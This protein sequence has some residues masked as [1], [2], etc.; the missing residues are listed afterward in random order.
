M[1]LM[2]DR[3]AMPAIQASR[4]A[5]AEFLPCAASLTKKNTRIS[6]KKLPQIRRLFI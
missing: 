4:A 5:A 2:F 6:A 3:Q 1:R